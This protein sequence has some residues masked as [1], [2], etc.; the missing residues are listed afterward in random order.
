[1]QVLDRTNLAVQLL[2]AWSGEDPGLGYGWLCR[3]RSRGPENG[4]TD[5]AVQV[6]TPGGILQVH[7]Q[8]D[9]RLSLT[10]P[11]R[12]VCRGEYYPGED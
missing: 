7:W 11:A 3:G 1:M 10:G 6:H 5:R 12:I 4:A 9:N 2:G 8:E